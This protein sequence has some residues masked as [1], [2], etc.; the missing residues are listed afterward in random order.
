MEMN[1]K[2]GWYDQPIRKKLEEV[3]LSD[4]EVMG[5]LEQGAF[6]MPRAEAEAKGFLLAGEK[7]A[8]AVFVQTANLEV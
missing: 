3:I 5:R 6:L 4:R 7:V 1:S 2:T 8:T